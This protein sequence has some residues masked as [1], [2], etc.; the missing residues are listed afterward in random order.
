[1]LQRILLRARRDKTIGSR[2]A[3]RSLPQGGRSIRRALLT[4]PAAAL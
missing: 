1:M 2:P 3:E 4:S